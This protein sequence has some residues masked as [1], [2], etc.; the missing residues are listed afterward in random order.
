[1]K[2]MKLYTNKEAVVYL[3][4]ERGIETTDKALALRIARGTLPRPVNSKPRLTLWTKA[5]LDRMSPALEG[6][7]NVP[8]PVRPRPSTRKPK[9]DPKDEQ[10][11]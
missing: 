2:K 3:R 9:T 6:R 4:E 1:M 10:A 11:A 8:H 5:E 7:P